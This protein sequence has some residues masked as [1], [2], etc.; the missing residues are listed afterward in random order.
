MWSQVTSIF[1]EPEVERRR[2]AGVFDEIE[3]DGIFRFIVLMSHDG[4]SRVLFNREFR[5]TVL[6]T[7]LRE[8]TEGEEVLVEDLG[9]VAGF[10]P[11]LDEP[12]TPYV[13][14][15]L[16]STG[17]TL[18][19][20]L[21]GPMHPDARPTF[22]L[23]AAFAAT[24]RHALK[25]GHV[26][27]AL[28]N[29]CSAVELLA[30]AE[31]LLAPRPVADRI[32]DET[33][34]RRNHK[35]IHEPFADWARLGNVPSDFSS[36]L[37]R[38]FQLRAAAR[39]QNRDLARELKTDEAETLLHRMTNMETHVGSG[40]NGERGSDQS[41]NVWATRDIRAGEMVADDSFTVRRGE[42][43]KA[44]ASVRRT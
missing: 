25:T 9:E 39:Y 40:V 3:V 36:L 31:L 27:V 24:A 6:A 34:K 5:G 11:D 44:L 13:A 16:T 21:G 35:A 26:A 41:Y 22:E 42:R 4:Q 43:Q 15:L 23:A 2:A 33:S 18:C 1:I 12:G 19:F 32:A 7:P 30:K 8:V 17:W 37:G 29:A 10:E 14:G 28:D 20:Q 38:L